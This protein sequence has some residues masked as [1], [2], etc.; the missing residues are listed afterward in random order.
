MKG[1]RIIFFL[2]YLKVDDKNEIEKLKISTKEFN[3]IEDI[4]FLLNIPVD[5][6]KKIEDL[7]REAYISKNYEEFEKITREF[8]NNKYDNWILGIYD[9]KG[10]TLFEM[11][12]VNDPPETE[13]IVT[14]REIFT[15]NPNTKAIEK[16]R[17][18]LVISSFGGSF[19]F[20]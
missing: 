8:L 20:E 14:E 10:F 17:I 3:V 4:N 19:S 2:V 7:I 12:N 11:V 6:N 13:T 18:I 1:K 9:D 15:Q 16:I 5:Q